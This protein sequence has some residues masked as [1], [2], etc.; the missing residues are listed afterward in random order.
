MRG[1]RGSTRTTTSAHD[2]CRWHFNHTSLV[3]MQS[4]DR[5]SSNRGNMNGA[6]AKDAAG[7]TELFPFLDPNGVTSAEA[8]AP[9]DLSDADLL[10]LL[11][12]LDRQAQGEQVEELTSQEDTKERARISTPEPSSMTRS[13]NETNSPSGSTRVR[14]YTARKV[15]DSCGDRSL[16]L[17][18][19]MVV[20]MCL[21]QREIERLLQELPHLESY[22]DYLKHRAAM[23]HNQTDSLGKTQ[24]VNATLR[25]SIYRQQYTL[26]RLQSA[27]SFYR[28]GTYPDV[29]ANEC[30]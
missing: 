9:N 13:P 11:Q 10:E 8:S 23:A 4:T 24:L 19:L 28:V 3:D 18:R 21:V 7:F 16:H 17:N 20:N 1:E 6:D 29:L 26:A 22:V 25:E 5:S 14:T 30:L 27:M 2:A 12:A 15:R